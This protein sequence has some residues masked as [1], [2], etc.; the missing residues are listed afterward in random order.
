[1][2]DGKIALVTGG[3]RGIGRSIAEELASQGA[4]VYINYVSNINSAEELKTSLNKLGHKCE[5]IKCDVSSRE[6]TEEMINTI[7]KN[8][9]KLDILINNAGITKDN[10]I[11]RMKPEEWEM[12][13]KTNLT[14]AFNCS[15]L[16][17]KAMM[18]QRFGRIVNIS[19]VVGLTGNPGQANYA[20]AKA[21]MIGLTKTLAKELASR[22]ITVNAIAPGFI[23]TDMTDVLK[24][25]VKEGMLKNIPL[26]RFGQPQDIAKAVLFLVSPWADYITG[27]VLQVDGGMAI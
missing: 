13:I 6:E 14:G 11:I 15:Q 7:L 4:K 19:S 21:G 17:A 27:Q 23:E 26:A 18:K 24:N 20:S 10:L 22:N 2:L 8:E 1:M 3:S 12:T 9:G 5:I 25:E 16:S